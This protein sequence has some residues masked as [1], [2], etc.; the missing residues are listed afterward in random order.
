MGENEPRSPQCLYFD[1]DEHPED[2]LKVFNEFCDSFTLRYNALY[3]DPPKVSM[4]SAI[5]RWKVETATQEAPDPRP[6]V[7][8][9]D[10]IRDTWRSHD[11]VH[12]FLGLF[13]SKRFY[14]DWTAAQPDEA[15]RNNATWQQFMKYVREFYKP[16]ENPTLKNFHFREIQQSP[17]ETFTAF[18]NRVALE[19]GHCS[20]KCRHDD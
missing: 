19:A 6:T 2:T 11:K 7:A 18:A 13:S 3:P 8:Q 5:A 9:Y 1:P 14:N 10:G 15:L 17:K 20:F 12:K 16:T 4:D